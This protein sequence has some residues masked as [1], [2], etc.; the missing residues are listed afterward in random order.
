M[1]FGHAVGLQKTSLNQRF[2]GN[3]EEFFDRS[4]LWKKYDKENMQNNPILYAL[5]TV[6]WKNELI[7]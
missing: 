4:I 3:E 6:G 5:V 1:C 7:Y 2:Y